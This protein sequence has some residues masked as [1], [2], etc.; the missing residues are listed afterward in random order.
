MGQYIY[1]PYVVRYTKCVPTQDLASR[2]SYGMMM[3]KESER[4]FKLGRFK[5]LEDS[6]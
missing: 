5:S 2:Q 4:P 6:Q 1:I 3:Y